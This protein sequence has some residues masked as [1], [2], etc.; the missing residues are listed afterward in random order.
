MRSLLPASATSVVFTSSRS[1]FLADS[2]PPL[3]ALLPLFALLL[4]APPY[5]ATAVEVGAVREDEMMASSSCC[6]ISYCIISNMALGAFTAVVL[7]L[8]FALLAA[9]GLFA[10]DC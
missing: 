4:F 5:D 6:I 7:L 1:L 3:A 10:A 2:L 9:A 8:A